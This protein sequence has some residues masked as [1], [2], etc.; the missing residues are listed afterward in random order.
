MIK[1]PSPRTI[2]DRKVQDKELQFYQIDKS[3]LTPQL[4]LDEEFDIEKYISEM[5]WTGNNSYSL[6]TNYQ[7]A[8]RNINYITN[9]KSG[10][11]NRVYKNKELQ[12]IARSLGLSSHGKKQDLVKIIREA[13]FNYFGIDDPELKKSKKKK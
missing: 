2:L 10:R 3:D 7:E 13:V 12:A 4:S 6:P 1:L 5:A 11:N 9:E 8:Y